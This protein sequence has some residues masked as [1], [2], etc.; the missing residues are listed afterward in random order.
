M[1]WIYEIERRVKE[2]NVVCI[3]KLNFQNHNT[4]ASNFIFNIFSSSY[5]RNDRIISVLL[6]SCVSSSS[7]DSVCAHVCLYEKMMEKPPSITHLFNVYVVVVVVKYSSSHLEV[8]CALI[9][10]STECWSDWFNLMLRT[11]YWQQQQPATTRKN[12][13]TNDVFNH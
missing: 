10:F 9:F 12:E 13:H 11:L 3:V 2:W 4:R 6:I 1:G 5:Y 7:W 8:W